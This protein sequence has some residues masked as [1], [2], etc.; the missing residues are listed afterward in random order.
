ML[1]K[2]SPSLSF[3]ALG[4]DVPAVPEQFP[5]RAGGGTAALLHGGPGHPGSVAVSTGL[6][7]ARVGQ[8]PWAAGQ[9]DRPHPPRAQ[10]NTARLLFCFIYVY[11]SL[12]VQ[13]HIYKFA[14][15]CTL[16]I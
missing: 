16:L 10:G 5:P 4:G 8:S 6:P 14:R 11:G 9:E 12:S 13:G 3:A 15:F 7:A 1:V 2:K